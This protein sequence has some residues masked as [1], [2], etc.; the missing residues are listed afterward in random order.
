MIFFGIYGILLLMCHLTPIT[1]SQLYNRFSSPIVPINCGS[2][3]APYNEDGIP[4]CCDIRH[5]IPTAY[6]AEWE[7]LRANTDLWQ[8]WKSED[9][10]L[11]A[12]LSSET[13]EG[14]LLIACRGIEYCQRGY[15]SISCRSF[16]FFP[17]IDSTGEFIG[18]SYYWEYEDRCWVISNLQK[19]SS[20]FIKE[21]IM[22]YEYLFATDVHD[23]ENYAHFSAH[24]RNTFADLKRS[25]PLL[26]RNGIA[27]KMSPR[28]ER[29]HR[30]PAE[31]FSKF[32]LY[33]IAAALPF[34]DEL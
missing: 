10:A 21:F 29:L 8:L 4:F 34:P 5:T 16:P 22:T 17:Y 15:R 13:P 12:E 25:I 9:S 31:S 1:F 26:H 24:M 11:T 32:G 14:Q 20:T 3:C 23:R 6:Q 7:Y 30:Y 33:K 2:K 19:V 27:Y 18:L 28:S